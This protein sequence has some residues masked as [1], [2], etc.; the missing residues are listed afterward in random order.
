MQ[1]SVMCIANFLSCLFDHSS[2]QLGLDTNSLSLLSFPDTPAPAG[3]EDLPA[4]VFINPVD[5][6][7]PVSS[8]TLPSRGKLKTSRKGKGRAVLESH[9]SSRGSKSAESVDKL[10]HGSDDALDGDMKLKELPP[11]STAVE[12]KA[13]VDTESLSKLAGGT[14][15]QSGGNYGFFFKRDKEKGSTVKESS[16]SFDIDK[17][18]KTTEVASS[19]QEEATSMDVGPLTVTKK[20]ET[21]FPGS[22]VTSAPDK[23]HYDIPRKLIEQIRS[24]PEAK[25]KQSKEAIDSKEKCEST[26]EDKHKRPSDQ[27]DGNTNTESGIPR[28][29][30]YVNVT[31]NKSTGTPVVKT[32]GEGI[33]DVPRSV[34]VATSSSPEKDKNGPPPTKPKV[35]PRALATKMTSVIADSYSCKAAGDN[36]TATKGTSASTE[37]LASNKSESTEIIDSINTAA[38]AAQH[39]NSVRS[40]DVTKLSTGKNNTPESSSMEAMPMKHKDNSG[41]DCSSVLKGDSIKKEETPKNLPL[42][43]KPQVLPRPK[44]TTAKAS[45]EKPRKHSSDKEKTKRSIQT[46]NYT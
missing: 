34:L 13:A 39:G 29:N 12:T 5:P 41:H 21:S 40:E 20:P 24:K 19:V 4:L 31:I 27:S 9:F 8:N 25:A 44:G 37:V 15:N 22:P 2:F 28:T 38:A 36:T 32:Q 46:Y 33:Y 3:G 43:G 17:D 10:G 16:T 7:I 11:Q 45:S 14:L 18:S 1:T 30:T 35:A 26:F 42:S 23:S 6:S